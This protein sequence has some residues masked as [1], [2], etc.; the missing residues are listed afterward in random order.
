MAGT[1]K[2]A[3][4]SQFSGNQ[5]FSPNL[6]FG[7]NLRKSEL[8]GVIFGCRNATMK[9]CLSKLLFGL[10]AQHFSYVRNIDPGLPL[11]LFNYTDR[12][13]HG[14]FE[15]ASKGRMFIDPYGWTNDGS[16]RT[17]YPAQV[18]ICVR[19][20]CQ[21]LPEDKFKELLADN[22][23]IN[24]HFWFELDHAQTS[25][26]ISVLSSR[27]IVSGNS[28]LLNTQNWMTLSR[29]LASNETWGEDE[30]CKMLELETDYSAH[31]S[32]RTYWTEND[33]SLAEH[34]QPLDT[35][36]VE[37]DVNEDEMNSVFLKLKELTVKSESQEFS[38]AN[39]VNDSPD[40]NSIEKGYTEVSDGLDKKEE[41]S[42]PP[43]E[44]QYNIA[45]FVQE[46]KELTSFKKIQKE[47]NS[48]LE[49]KLIE[50]EMEIQHLKDRCTLLES[51]CNIPSCLEHVEKGVMK[52]TVEQ[53][54]DPK[55]SLFLIGGFDGKSWLAT[56]DLYSTS[57]SVIKPCKP[58]NSVRSYAS[59]VRLN[60]E[61]YVFGGGNGYIWYDT[62]ESYNPV[63]DN[64]TMRPSLNQKKGSLSGAAFDGKI[65]AVGGGNGV[66]CFSDVEMLDLDI[67]RWIPTRSMLKK[68]FAL[69]AVE[70]NGAIYATGG[71]DGT[72]YLR[73]A[74]RFDPREHSWTKL[75]DMNVKR[76][77]H[78]LV[79]LNEKL[80]ALGGFDGD[81]MVQSIEVFDPRLG[82]W[83]MGEPMS[84]PRGY[85]AAVVVKESIYMIGGVRVGE[86]IVDIVENY[87]EGQGWQETC[88]TTAVKRCFLSAI[89]Y[90]D[91]LCRTDTDMDTGL[92][93]NKDTS[94]FVIFK[95]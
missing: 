66:D 60:G 4:T 71:F 86:N 19:L 9:E 42:D 63:H 25:K 92:D 18:Q 33:Y 13:L 24:N 32:T 29:P 46:V 55:D 35:N 69:A 72:D 93:I 1:W 14:I 87:T 58:M 7:R 45:Q 68:R 34:I 75:P 52:S 57:Q 22:Y 30:T 64:W 54:L 40:M 41:S 73:S 8:G 67:G 76:G 37:N 28:V 84:H 62:V 11:F 89:A 39:N 10:P 94:T 5:P 47:R 12:K 15:A 77:C 36:E 20:Q 81:K 31:S 27:S 3:H 65:F 43:F 2:K 61:I 78:S 91:E 82:A 88:T 59:V 51:A 48:Y 50:A 56:M 79:V 90:S 80:Y 44:Y 6:S 70:L 23:Y 53:H 74:E 85:C 21:P 17:Q 95:M 26:L 38:L 49:Q 83:T 16:E